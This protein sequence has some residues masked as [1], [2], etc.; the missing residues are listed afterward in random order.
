MTLRVC[1]PGEWN[2][3]GRSTLWI[4]PY[5]ARVLGVSDASLADTG[6]Q[7]NNAIYPLHAGT[8]G[9]LWHALVIVSG[10]L[11]PFFL[12]TGFLFWRARAK[13]RD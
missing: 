6:V 1:M 2:P 13:R 4:D 7:V 5:R 9:P 8:T 10:L 11:P 12:V 3:T